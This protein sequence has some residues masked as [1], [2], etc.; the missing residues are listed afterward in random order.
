MPPPP[1]VKPAALVEIKP[2]QFLE[3]LAITLKGIMYSSDEQHNRAIIADNK[4]EAQKLYKVGDALEDAVGK[5]ES[6]TADDSS[7]NDENTTSDDPE[8]D[9]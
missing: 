5:G 3:P 9:D 1:V 8:K 6:D 2:V 4:S 7:A